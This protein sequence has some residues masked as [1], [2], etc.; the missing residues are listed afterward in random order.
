MTNKTPDNLNPHTKQK[1]EAINS[2][3]P[4]DDII[5]DLNQAFHFSYNK[6]IHE[7]HDKLGKKG[8]PVIIMFGDKVML[9]HDGEQETI[10]VIPHLYHRI[11][12]I[13]HISF[14]VFVTLSN[15]GIGALKETVKIDL[16]HEKELIE[17]ALEILADEPIPADHMPT[18]RATLENA[19]ILINDVLESGEVLESRL[20]AFGKENA[21]LYLDNAAFGAQLE[22]DLLHDNVTRWKGEIGEDN[23]EALYVVICA[24]HQ[25][26]Y[27]ELTRQYFQKLLHER[28][29]LG[30]GLEDR[31]IYAEHIHEVDA[32]LDLLARHIN[33]QTA[34]NTFFG[35][36]MRLQQDLM[37]EGAASYLE[38]LLPDD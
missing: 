17:K 3:D 36:K 33:D 20:K 10:E 25:A 30:A 26:R 1:F 19:I 16:E 15:N 35:D 13:S 34:S 2:Y 6:M 5:S 32:A 31:V 14:G 24:G 8:F 12:S 38:E 28:D 7:A 22:L 11:K 4:Y 37:S 29:G 27:R 23:W 9:F 21:P 18:Q